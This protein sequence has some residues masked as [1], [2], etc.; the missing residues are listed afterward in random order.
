VK[1]LGAK[2]RGLSLGSNVLILL[3]RDMCISVYPKF[4]AREGTCKGDA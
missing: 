1:S 2:P 4:L 3:K